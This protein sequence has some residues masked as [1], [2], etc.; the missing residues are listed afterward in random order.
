MTIILL[1]IRCTVT[2]PMSDELLYQIHTHLF[3]P[4]DFQVYGTYKLHT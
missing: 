2:H 3:I 4:D 1:K